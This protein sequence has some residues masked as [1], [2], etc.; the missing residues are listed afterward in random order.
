MN[1][2]KYEE[3]LGQYFEKTLE[4]AKDLGVPIFFGKLPKPYTNTTCGVY[5]SETRTIWISTDV[6]NIARPTK[7][8]IHT[9]VHEIVHSIQ[10]MLDAYEFF[11]L[12]DDLDA[13]KANEIWKRTVMEDAPLF[14]VEADELA[15]KICE[16]W[17]MNYMSVYGSYALRKNLK[18]KHEFLNYM[19]NEAYELEV[20][21]LTEIKEAA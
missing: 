15:I 1:T 19:W 20:E 9:I 13:I 7:G 4:L 2:R 12:P 18:K 8:L 16:S 3:D 17:G 14:E 6:Y 21:P 10:H 5:F 11:K